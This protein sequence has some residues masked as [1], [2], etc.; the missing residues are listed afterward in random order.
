MF[1]LDDWLVLQERRGLTFPRQCGLSAASMGSQHR[2]HLIAWPVKQA[3]WELMMPPQVRPSY[4]DHGLH[5]TEA[6]PA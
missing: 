5:E 3:C 1:G 2:L 4:A 6:A